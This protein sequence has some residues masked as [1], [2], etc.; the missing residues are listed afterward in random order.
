M[1]H[2]CVFMVFSKWYTGR[3]LVNR[4]HFLYTARDMLI[5]GSKKNHFAGWQNNSKNYV[6]VLTVCHSITSFGTNHYS[7]SV[8]TM[9]FPSKYAINQDCITEKQSYM[10]GNV[11]YWVW[12]PTCP[13]DLEQGTL[14]SLWFISPTYK[15]MIFIFNSEGH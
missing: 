14:S 4:R 7:L 5:M 3:Q 2:F 8:S 10:R 13:C 6:H 1:L 12:I 9:R 11:V 15:M